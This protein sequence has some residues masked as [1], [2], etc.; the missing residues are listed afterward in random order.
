MITAAIQSPLAAASSARLPVWR[1]LGSDIRQAHTTPDALAQAA[2]D[3][4][5]SELPIELSLP[6]TDNRLIKSHKA[7]VRAD[8]QDLLGVVGTR[9]QPIQ[10]REA[11]RFLDAI[12]GEFKLSLETAGELHGGRVVWMLVR[13]PVQLRVADTDDVSD[14][15]L[16][17]VNSHDGTMAFRVLTTMIRVVCQNTLTLALRDGAGHG[18]SFRHF[19]RILDR[20][21]QARRAVHGSMA[22]VARLNEEVQVLGAKRIDEKQ[23]RQYLKAVWPDDPDTS[24]PSRAEATRQQLL[25]NYHAEGE[26]IPSIAGTAWAAVNAVTH[27]ADYQRPSR[28]VSDHRKLS[29]RL[30]SIW[31][32]D[33]AALKRRAWDLAIQMARD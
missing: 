33:S 10:N 14:P 2:L 9:Y 29:N 6:F 20:V 5:V 1:Q 19:P 31:F 24:D 11:F 32:G 15:Y 3:W 8:T 26:L 22:R 23:T 12:L 17:C 28:G 18:V 16:L 27:F 4:E 21:D 25:D 7:I 30:E 13:L